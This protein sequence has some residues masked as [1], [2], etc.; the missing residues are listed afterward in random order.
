MNSSPYTASQRSQAIEIIKDK[1]FWISALKPPQSNENAYFF[2]VDNDLIYEP[3]NSDFGPL[4][5]A[6]THKYVREMVRLL[7]DPRYKETKI[8]H[9][10]SQKPDK[11]ANACYLMGAFMIIVLKQSAEA[12]W[13]AFSPY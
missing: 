5:L 11:Q 12:A 2:N 10:T 4:N 3:F 1:L 8:Y 13:D 9:Y 7:T 6:N